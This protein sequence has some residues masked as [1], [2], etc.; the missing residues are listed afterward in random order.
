MKTATTT[1]YHNGMCRKDSG[2]SRTTRKGMN[3]RY[4]ASTKRNQQTSITLMDK[5]KQKQE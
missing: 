4:N 3:K 5:L 1:D 2:Q